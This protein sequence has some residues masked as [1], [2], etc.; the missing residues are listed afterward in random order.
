MRICA[1]Y[2][3]K[4]APLTHNI[5][6]DSR[7]RR[8]ST[9]GSRLTSLVSVGLVLLLLGVA[10]LT[11]MAGAELQHEVR[12]TLG[13]TIVMDSDA[14]AAQ[15]NGVKTALMAHRA[16]DGFSFSS[17]EE[18][19][20]SESEAMGQDIVAMVEG[21]PYSSEF[22][23][24][25]RP[26]YANTDSIEAVSAFFGELPGVDKLISESAVI[27]NVD[28]MMNRTAMI[29]AAFGILVLVI[30]IALVANT[31]SLSVYGRRFIIH[32]MK[33][34]GA[35]PGYIRRPFVR[36]GASGG[37]VAGVVSGAVLAL[38]RH[39]AA[40]AVPAVNDLLPWNNVVLVAVG[41]CVAG[42]L[43]AGLTSL[44]AA[45]RYIKASYDDMFL[46]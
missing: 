14:P 43:L 45:N 15:V 13:F 2:S 5:M 16:V 41:M 24:R 26:A 23:V 6:S 3:R 39:Y 25:V 34:V 42:A 44:V 4:V 37:L 1:Y 28:R 20:A 7:K 33:L 35:T 12:S 19:L 10:T 36:A 17:A 30:A 32:T 31:V 22:D 8:I 38:L 18:I 29:L 46:K 27:E 11:A 40:Q 9:L 21:N